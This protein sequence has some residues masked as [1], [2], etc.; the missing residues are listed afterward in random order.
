L[1][2]PD[3]LV[4]IAALEL[5]EQLAP[6]SRLSAAG[7]LLKDEIRG[8]R[9]RAARVLADAPRTVFPEALRTPHEQALSEYVQALRLNSDWPAENV[10]LGNLFVKQR[11]AAE[12]RAAYEHA[13]SLDPRFIGAYVNLADLE[14]QE[15]NDARAETILRRG[16]SV[17]PAAADL[18]YALGL[19]LIRKK[20]REGALA[21]LAQA[22]TLAPD[23]ARYAYVYAV[24]LQSAGRRD[25]A[26]KRLEAFNAKHPH[27]IQ[28]LSALI[29]MYR[30]AGNRASALA[31]AKTLATILP[32]DRGVMRLIEQLERH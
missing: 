1:S 5:T 16:S 25:E 32:G 26:L 2:D 3:P 12:A 18:R 21:E 14:R 6:A 17:I 10:N 23:N 9:I 15:G 27:D 8:V 13:L 24:A 7:P 22:A 29:A 4:R 30:E 28:V 11:R 20:D 31:L 19:T